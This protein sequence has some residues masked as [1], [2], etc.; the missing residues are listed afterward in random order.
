MKKLIFLFCCLVFAGIISAQNIEIPII[1]KPEY[2]EV[3]N[4]HFVLS[5]RTKLVLNDQGK[6]KNEIAHLQALI[7]SAIGRELSIISAST[8]NVPESI[9]KNLNDLGDM[10]NEAV[11]KVLPSDMR[12]NSIEIK[13]TDTDLGPEAYTLFITPGKVLISANTTHGAFNAIQ[14][15]RQL[16]PVETEDR[17]SVSQTMVS[18]PCIDIKDSPAYGWRGM[19]LDVSRHFFTVD[20]IKKHI[21]R[22]ALYKLNKLH[23]HLTDDQ[24]WRIEIKKY[25]KLTSEGAWRTFNNQDSACIKKSKENP[26][27]EIDKRF[28]HDKDGKTVYGGF[29]T[30][31]E[32]KDIISYAASRHIEIIPE[33]DMPGHMMAAIKAY[34][35]LI[36]GEPRWG[37][38]FSIPLCA[39]KEDVYT[40]SEDILSEIA[41]LFPSKYIHIGADEVEK[42]TWETSALCKDFMKQHNIADVNKLQSHFVHRM[43]KFVE[44]KGKQIIGWDEVL[45]GGANPDV[46]VM[47]WRGWVKN[48][49]LKAVSGGNKVIMTPTNPLY[50]DYE[51]NSTSVYNVYTMDVV[52]PN[53]PEDKKDLILGAQ[54]NLWTEMIPSEQQ[55]EFQMYPRMLALA[56]RVWTDDTKNFEEFEQRLLKHFPRLDILGVNYRLP[57]IEGFTQ[58]NVF[59]GQTDF[60]A[61][62]PIDGMTIHY[63]MDGSIP[64]KQ[65][66]ALSEPVRISD[67]TLLKMALFSTGGARGEIYDLEFAPT[68]LKKAV[69]STGLNSGLKCDFFDKYYKSTKGIKGNPDESF[70]VQNIVAPKETNRFGLQFTGFIDVPETGIY[71]FYFTCDDGG[72]LYIDDEVIIDNDGQHSAIRKSGQAALEKGLHPF[73]IDFIEAGGGYTL[74][75]QYSFNGSPLKDIPDSWFKY[76]Q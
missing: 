27:F 25:P 52:Y 28:I 32:M 22:L 8:Q 53:I 18:L 4:G 19:H 61:E 31:E 21:D 56:E 5:G 11:N 15:I 51:N 49:P 45:D 74:K 58:K 36:E 72:V 70:V 35:H 69:A 64:S 46:T 44:S 43:Q 38:T 55:A 41:D 71:S 3:N 17:S 24:G 37:E 63:T 67:Q 68:Q 16:L 48:A 76:K 75:L 29:Y 62:S 12:Q 34:P 26:N 66:P 9:F 2:I 54:A 20:Y 13:Y 42:K 50:F 33:I 10:A 6:F 14:T 1:P 40:F 60:F 23:L 73:R 39:C 57:D 30:Q 7:K 59:I 65:S 47:Y